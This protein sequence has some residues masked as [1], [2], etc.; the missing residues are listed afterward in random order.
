[1]NLRISCYG[2]D[3]YA[4]NTMYNIIQGL[5]FECHTYN[6]GLAAS[7]GSVLFMAVPKERR[8]AAR[9]STLMMHNVQ[10]WVEGDYRDLIK[11]AETAKKLTDV[12]IQG[13]EKDMDATAEEIEEMM[14]EEKYLT[15]AECLQLGIVGDIY[16]SDVGAV[17]P[18]V[19]ADPKLSAFAAHYNK[20]KFENK[21]HTDM[22]IKIDPTLI[23]LPADSDQATVAAKLT[24]LN[25]QA[26]IAKQMEL[27][28]A[29]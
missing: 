29:Q 7:G 28:N 12:L 18:T 3:L 15:A 20:F 23:G 17:E 8:H 9:N 19:L 16:D 4:T 13:Y 1:M 25:Q 5:P 6:D 11:R 26:S 14:N 22:E 10:T 24:E 27:Q 21:N 2:G